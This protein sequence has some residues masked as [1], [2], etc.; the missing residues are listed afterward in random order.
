MEATTLHDSNIVR[1]INE[2]YIPVMVDIDRDS[3]IAVKFK[4]I[5]LPTLIVLTDQ[6]KIIKTI[7]GYHAPEMLEKELREDIANRL[8]QVHEV[9]PEKKT[10]RFRLPMTIINCISPL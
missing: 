5:E 6:Q 2:K 7:K 3:D 9:I 4:V 8:D 10:N 1:L